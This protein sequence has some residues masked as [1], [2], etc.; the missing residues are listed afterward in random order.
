MRY[1]DYYE[2]RTL[3]GLVTIERNNSSFWDLCFN[4]VVIQGDYNDPNQAAED[5]SRSE[6][7]NLILKVPVPWELKQWFT[8]PSRQLAKNNQN[9]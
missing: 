3:K 9:N 2:W 8:S 6:I 1:S 5:A 7:N 4:G